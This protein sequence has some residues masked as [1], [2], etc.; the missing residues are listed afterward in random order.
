MELVSSLKII[1]TET[2]SNKKSGINESLLMLLNFSP[3]INFKAET[4]SRK[5]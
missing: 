3:M 1:N 4:R 2:S 5:L